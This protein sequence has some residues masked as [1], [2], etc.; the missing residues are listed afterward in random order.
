GTE[1]LRLVEPG[2]GLHAHADARRPKTRILAESARFEE[3]LF[4][5]LELRES[6]QERLAGLANQRRDGASR[7]GGRPGMQTRRGVEELPPK[8]WVVINFRLHDGETGS[9]TLLPGMPK[10]GFD[11]V[12]DRQ[13]A[14]GLRGD[15]HRVFPARLG[16]QPEARP[17]ALEHARGLVG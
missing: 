6:A 13:F 14:I 8:D 12:L 16:Q 11:E 10:G 1:A 5:G 3:P 9:G 7:I 4:A 15:D 2:A 17:P